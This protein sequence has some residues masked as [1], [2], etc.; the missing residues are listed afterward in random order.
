MRRMKCLWGIFFLF[1]I[2]MA[3]WAKKDLTVLQWN[4][5]QEGTMVDGGY[6]AIVN[7]IV[8]L[9][10][11]FVTFSEVRNYRNVDFTKRLAASLREKGETYYSFY[12]YD[13]GLLSRYP[14]ID[15]MTVFPEKGDHGSIYKLLANVD[16]HKIAVYTAHLDYL[17]CAYYNVLGY[18][19]STWEKIP[20]TNSVDEILRIN[21]A[22]LRDDAIRAF[23]GE[24][25]K[26]LSNGYS[27]IIGGDFNEPSHL[28]W[29][30]RNKNLN[31]RQGMVIPW[32]VSTLLEQAGYKDAYRERYPDPVS[33]PGITYPSDNWK[34]DPL[35]V[36]WAP[37]AD[38]R[39]RIDFV[40]YKGKLKVKEAFV[41]G[42]EMSIAYG[43][44]VK[45][46]RQDRFIVPLDVWP[47]DHKGVYVVFRMK[48]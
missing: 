2:N 9:R 28:D 21:E 48:K 41:F 45:E 18:D 40:L 22:S 15:S 11:D 8:R 43:E 20:I 32:T 38:E 35:K 30:E 13:S 16:G 36:T 12:A 26:D 27:V 31:G 17:S 10:P 3:S 39:A 7:E 25:A 42:P 37:D 23:I 14:I 19:G 24:A 6:E 46:Q 44:R 4:I 29:L 33:H 47:T 5:W 34:K 1:F